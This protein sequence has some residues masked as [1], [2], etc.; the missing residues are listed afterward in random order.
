MWQGSPALSR[1]VLYEFTIIRPIHT[2]SAT[3]RKSPHLRDTEI[4]APLRASER[5]AGMEAGG[6]LRN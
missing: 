5:T 4:S 3:W 1:R 6:P 2:G